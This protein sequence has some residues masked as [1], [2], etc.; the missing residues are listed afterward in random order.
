MEIEGPSLCDEPSY[1][2]DPSFL[3]LA[4]LPR[5]LAASL[6]FAA[7]RSDDL[8][9]FRSIQTEGSEDSLAEGSPS[10]VMT[11][12]QVKEAKERFLGRET[13]LFDR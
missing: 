11:G 1:S 5:T 4:V 8:V 10:E 9:L 3:S 6:I 13:S 2:Q 12:P 7:P